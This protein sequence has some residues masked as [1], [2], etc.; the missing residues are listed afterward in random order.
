L[1]SRK[2]KFAATVSSSYGSWSLSFVPAPP[3]PSTAATYTVSGPVPAFGAVQKKCHDTMSLCVT[4]LGLFGSDE[5][6]FSPNT[7]SPSGATTVSSR[8]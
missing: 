4:S 3:L 8:V 2:K 1:A 7:V 6:T 5:Y